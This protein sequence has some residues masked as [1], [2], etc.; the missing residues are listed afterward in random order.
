MEI[1]NSE[2]KAM[3]LMQL[4]V[5]VE[6]SRNLLMLS[7]KS[8]VKFILDQPEK[9]IRKILFG[10]TPEKINGRMSEIRESVCAVKHGVLCSGNGIPG[11]R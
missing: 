1:K 2:L 3:A 7:K 5:S 4:A 6:D 9:F 8:N 11:A 10:S